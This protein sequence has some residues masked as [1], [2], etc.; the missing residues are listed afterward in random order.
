MPKNDLNLSGFQDD[1]SENIAENRRR[2]RLA[3]DCDFPIATVWQ[4]HSSEIKSVK[5]ELDIDE[6]KFKA[7]AMISRLPE[8]LL[9]VKTADCVP[10]LV[11]DRKT[12]SFAAVHAGWR[13]TADLILAKTIEKMISE[14]E[15]DPANLIAAIGPAACGKN[16]EIGQD[17]IDTFST[18][19]PK[20]A[21]RILV[22]TR[23]GHA[24]IDLHQANRQQLLD[25]GVL[26][27]NIYSAPLCTMERTDLFFSY[28][29]ENKLHGK[30]GR[31]MA[32][33]GRRG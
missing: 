18:N 2:F 20:L 1:S 12:A 23:E 3:L 29:V 6:A 4:I 16:Y 17:V 33:I 30:T 15:V 8:T 19:F 14:Y 27:E 32:V 24:L 31:L 21:T 28:R 7:D 9:G 10:I 26:S 13:G 5:S 25:R 22:P 11:G